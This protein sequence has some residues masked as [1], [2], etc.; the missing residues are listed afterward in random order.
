MSNEYDNTDDT[1]SEDNYFYYGEKEEKPKNPV[2]KIC[3]TLEEFIA[4]KILNNY[5]V[6]C[7]I[8]KVPKSSMNIFHGELGRVIDIGKIDKI[9]HV[10][11]RFDSNRKVRKFPLKHIIFL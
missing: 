4:H 9:T 10:W 1:R 11:V 8:V 6:E 2:K 5:L 3:S 7:K